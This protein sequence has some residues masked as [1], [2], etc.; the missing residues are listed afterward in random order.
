[1]SDEE[2]IGFVGFQESDFYEVHD[3]RYQYRWYRGQGVS[4]YLTSD[5]PETTTEVDY[6]TIGQNLWEL[7]LGDQLKVVEQ[8]CQDHLNRVRNDE[9]DEW[10]TSDTS[11]R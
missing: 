11:S 9:E 4:V 2:L 5:D 6:F 8:A 1:M 10:Q 7:D 3:Y